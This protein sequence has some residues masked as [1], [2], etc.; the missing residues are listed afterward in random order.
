MTSARRAY[1]L[2]LSAAEVSRTRK[3]C[4]VGIRVAFAGRHAMPR[5]ARIVVGA[6][7]AT[8]RDLASLSV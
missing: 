7:V 8:L 4:R 5:R 1:F 3:D 2:S 6:N